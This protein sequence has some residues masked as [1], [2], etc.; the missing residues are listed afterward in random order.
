MSQL[1][2]RLFN[3]NS[4]L[5]HQPPLGDIP[6]GNEILRKTLK[7]AWPSILEAFLM[8]LV[9]FIDTIM[10]S[11]LG[12]SAIAS[13]GLV[14]QP[15]MIFLAVFFALMPTVSA[16]V[17]RRRG[18]DDRQSAN[19][20]FKM[21]LIIALIFTAILTTVGLLFADDIMRLAG[22]APD[23]HT[24]AVAYFRIIIG[25]VGFNAVTMVINSAQRG[26]GNTKISMRTNLISNGVNIIGNYLLIGGNLGF[27]AL[28]VRGAAIATVFGYFCGSLLAI[29]TV[30]H[31]SSYVQLRFKTNGLVDRRSVSALSKMWLNTF[32]EQLVLRVGF[33]VNAM[34]LARLGSV[35]FATHNIA[36]QFLT[37]SFAFGDGL[38]VAAVSLVGY[39]L[40]Q[41]RGDMAK[42]YGGFCQ[43]IGFVCSAVV[44]VIYIVFG[45]MLF[46]LFSD[47][48]Q[49][50]HD[51]T[52]IM[53]LMCAI[54]LIQISQVVFSG[55]LRG[56]GDNRYITMVS[57]IN[58]GILRPLLSWLFS[59]F[60]GFGIIGA[61][62]GMLMDQG[63]RLLMTS[64]R[65][66]RGKWT[67]IQ[68]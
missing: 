53:W 65:F 36:M 61:W 37:I 9:G 52:I 11:S 44:S 39:S 29:S 28:G 42:I 33:L 64:I 30:F 24:D 26:S 27:P 4:I 58:I 10:V 63:I 23:T 57:F 22:S 31:H 18:E 15:R 46:S 25:F 6:P 59:T 67:S 51:G 14:T 16:L 60:F 48:P 41:R 12:D 20:I 21:A 3:V 34:I 54:V 8:A 13:V 68:L 32:I 49:V 35:A 17:A 62:I 66:Y 38:S 5:K 40:G 43:R 1:V 56:A 50:L 19:R 47:T 55:C 7:M 45:R 2:E